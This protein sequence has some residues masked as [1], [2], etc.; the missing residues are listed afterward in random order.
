MK[1]LTF[2]VT[3][4]FAI[5]LI[6]CGSKDEMKTVYREGESPVAM[7]TDSDPEMKAARDKATATLPTFIK[8]LEKPGEREFFIKV[9]LPNSE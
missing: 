2:S 6:G 5:G 3:A 7:V 8:E 1:A 9:A 4:L